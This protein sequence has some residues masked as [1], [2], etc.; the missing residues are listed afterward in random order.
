MTQSHYS[1]T[2]NRPDGIWLWCLHCE[3]CYK[4]GEFR[5]LDGFQYCPYPDCDGT[6]VL[7][8]WTWDSIRAIHTDYPMEPEREKV[9]PLYP[10]VQKEGKSER[11]KRHKKRT[12]AKS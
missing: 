10:E 6:T 8:G 5:E 1:V 11:P 7:D 2:F 3:R 12:V 9:Y 4:A